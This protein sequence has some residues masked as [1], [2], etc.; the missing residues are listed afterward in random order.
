LY[1]FQ[2]FR[3]IGLC[4]PQD[5]ERVEHHGLFDVVI[6]FGVSLKTWGLVD[7]QQPRFGVLVDEDVEA[8]DFEADL[9]GAIVGL[10]HAIVVDKVG[11]DG[12]HGLDDEVGDLELEEVDIHTILLQ[13]IIYCL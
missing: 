11:L 3:S 4:Q 10:A 13:P 9:E 8:Q 12:H 6:E 1:A 2:L 5:L 7:F